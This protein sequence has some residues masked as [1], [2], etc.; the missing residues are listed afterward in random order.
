MTHGDLGQLQMYVNYYDRVEKLADEQPTIGI[1]LCTE[2][3][4]RLVKFALP[5]TNQT[6]LASKYEMIFPSEARLLAEIAKVETR[7]AQEQQHPF[8]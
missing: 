5:D 4:D 1:L 6:I 2:K 3:N 7:L 8:D